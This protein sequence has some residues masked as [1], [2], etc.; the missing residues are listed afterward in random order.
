MKIELGNSQLTLLPDRAVHWPEQDA[1]LVADVHLG[2]DQVFRRQGMAVPAGVLGQDLARLS[3]LIRETAAKRLLILGDWVHAPPRSGEPWADDIAAWRAVMAPLE[4]DLVLGNHDRQLDHWLKR[5]GIQGHQDVLE[6][7]GL[8]L[9]HEWT[10]D[11]AG[12]GLSG[13]LHPGVRIRSARENLRLPAF[14]R[15]PDH[16]VLPAFGGFT[17]LMEIEDFPATERYVTTGR[18]V[19]KLP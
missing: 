17:G 2:K 1:V 6:I 10:P 19:L 5:W 14:L 12:P 3:T 18:Q 13:H 15:S 4:I 7:G 16:L 8:R 9:V 11:M